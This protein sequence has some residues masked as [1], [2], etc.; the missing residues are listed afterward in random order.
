MVARRGSRGWPA[1]A[2]CMVRPLWPKRITALA[3]ER[4]SPASCVSQRSNS[5]SVGIAPPAKARDLTWA[6]RASGSS[7]NVTMEISHKSIW[8][9]R[10]RPVVASRVPTTVRKP[11]ERPSSAPARMSESVSRARA[12]SSIRRPRANRPCAFSF[13]SSHTP[14]GWAGSCCSSI[15]MPRAVRFARLSRK[16]PGST[17][18][19]PRSGSLNRLAYPE[20]VPSGST[21]FRSR[22]MYFSS[23]AWG[24]GLS[25]SEMVIPGLVPVQRPVAHRGAFLVGREEGGLVDA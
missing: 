20:K 19:P 21:R 1:A 14:M 23:G 18:S 25:F 17:T 24:M 7:G 12:T 22:A 11:M 15:L 9:R 10:R 8:A 2:S 13:S 3:C 6:T 5:R 16:A 4:D